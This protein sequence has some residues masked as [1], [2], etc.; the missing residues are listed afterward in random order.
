MRITLKDIVEKTGVSR[1]VVSMYLN[2]DP[3]VRLSEEKKKRIDEAV[4]ELGYRPSLAACA[5]RKGH[6]KMLGLVLGGITDAYF[7]HLAEACLLFSEAR[8]YQLLFALT[9]WGQEKEQRSLENLT[10]RQVDGIFYA[11]HLDDN[12][13]FTE[14]I[15][16]P[17][18]P[19][20]LNRREK[21]GFLGTLQNDQE[22]CDRAVETFARRGHRTVACHSFYTDDFQRYFSTACATHGVECKTFFYR[23]YD[24]EQLLDRLLKERPSA[25][26]IV[27][28]KIAAFVL[29]AAKELKPDYSPEIITHYNFPVD[30]LDSPQIIGYVFGNFYQIAKNSINFL[31]DYIESKNKRESADTVLTKQYFYSRE[32]FF[33]MKDSFID[34]IN[35]AERNLL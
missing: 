6:T 20:L 25:I 14:R 15:L 26:Y 16:R 3:R 13:V 18:I 32:E 22:I 34:T 31:I 27:D 35:K 5:L 11:P 10:E 2:R 4:R 21:S 7:S 23:Q 29:Q 19:I 1:S 30:L 17:G 24:R 33:R 12:P 8:G 28:C 9:G